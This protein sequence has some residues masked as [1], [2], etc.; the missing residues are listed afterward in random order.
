MNEFFKSTSKLI[1]Q[2]S[3][4]I[5]FSICTI[6]CG[7]MCGLLHWSSSQ[8]LLNLYSEGSL[9]LWNNH[10]FQRNSK[11]KSL[12]SKI[13]QTCV[14]CA[15]LALTQGWKCKMTLLIIYSQL[16]CFISFNFTAWE[17]QLLK[18]KCAE[19]C[20]HAQTL[21]FTMDRIDK[22]FYCSFINCCWVLLKPFPNQAYYRQY[23]PSQ[24]HCVL[25]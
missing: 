5:C 20:K 15:K 13:G 4:F 24:C 8:I 7:N 9:F 1:L 25:S 19:T 6:S 16:L 12:I 17:A 10:S 3:F 18:L 23:S 14:W 2:I 22:A 11:D 21:I